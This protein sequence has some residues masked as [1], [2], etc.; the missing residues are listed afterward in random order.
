MDRREEDRR[1]DQARRSQA[2]ADPTRP[3]DRV[4]R[5]SGPARPIGSVPG[6]SRRPR[7]VGVASTDA[8]SCRHARRGLGAAFPAT[9]GGRPG[10]AAPRRPAPAPP[11]RRTPGPSPPASRRP[12][13][14]PGAGG[15]SAPRRRIAS[16]LDR[17]DRRRS[18]GTPPRPRG[19]GPARSSPAPSPKSAGRAPDGAASRIGQDDHQGQVD[20]RDGPDGRDQPR[21]AIPRSNPSAPRTPTPISVA[22]C[23]T[24]KASTTSIAGPRQRAGR[25]AV[26]PADAAR[27]AGRSPAAHARTIAQSTSG[28]QPEHDHASG[29]AKGPAHLRVPSASPPRSGR[30]ARDSVHRRPGP[31]ALATLPDSRRSPRIAPSERPPGPFRRRPSPGRTPPRCDPS[32]SSWNSSDGGSRRSPPRPSSVKKLERSVATGTPLRVKYGIDPTGIDVHLGHTVPLRKLR[33]FQDL[34]HTAVIIIGNYTA[35]VGDPSGRDETRAGADPG[36]GRGQRPRL[37][38]PGRQDHRPRPR[39]GPPQRRLVRRSGRSS[40]CST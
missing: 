36:A 27:P 8:G 17:V 21:V 35:L 5:P 18:A 6:R 30:V 40:T 11:P 12:A 29:T 19:R 39:R 2:D 4:P 13:A 16:E 24:A 9:P 23:Q 20:Q 25:A 14:S 28:R 1:Q 10:T 34:G 26:R 7:P 38:R 15:A 22:T 31:I 33:Q 37:P 3:A 32:P